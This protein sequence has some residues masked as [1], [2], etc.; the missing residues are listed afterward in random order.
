MKI[1]MLHMQPAVFTMV[2]TL[3]AIKL[4]LQWQRGRHLGLTTMV[5]V[6]VVMGVVTGAG[7]TEMVVLTDISMVETVRVHIER[8]SR[9]STFYVM[10]IVVLRI[11][12]F[13]LE[14]S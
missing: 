1:Q 12:V 13:V 9:S 11:F 10:K 2:M 3:E 6:E 8:I 4:V 5:V 14:G 7:I